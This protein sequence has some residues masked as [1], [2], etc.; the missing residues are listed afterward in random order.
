M[1]KRDITAHI[2]ILRRIKNIIQFICTYINMCKFPEN[3]IEN[4]VVN[5]SKT[6]QY[7]TG[8]KR[9]QL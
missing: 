9:A 6:M 7:W 4:V 3:K 2:Q 8:K 5:L 1:V